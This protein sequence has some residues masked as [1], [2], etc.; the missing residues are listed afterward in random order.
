[1]EKFLAVVALTAI[2]V[3]LGVGNFWFTF[4]L[5]PKSWASMAL[6]SILSAVQTQVVK[7]VLFPDVKK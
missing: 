3:A 2:A 7:A 4:G 5:W 6:F 1:M